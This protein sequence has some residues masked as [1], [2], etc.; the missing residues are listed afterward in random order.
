MD[1]KD[2]GQK[3]P[4]QEPGLGFGE[5]FTL[6]LAQ[7]LGEADLS[8]KVGSEIELERLL[9]PI[10]RSYVRQSLGIRR[11]ISTRPCS[12]TGRP[13]RKRVMDGVQAAAEMPWFLDARTRAI[14]SSR[15]LG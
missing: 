11:G 2:R 9:R 8:V 1:L 10:V 13:R 14:S 15:T 3:V 12:P 5:S 4:S 7:I 6:R